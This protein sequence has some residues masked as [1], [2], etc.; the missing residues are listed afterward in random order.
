MI[1]LTIIIFLVILLALVLVHEWGHFIVAKLIGCTVE[2]FGFGF[3]PRLFGIK[4]RGTLYS[5]NTL[6]IGGFV[7]IEGEDMQLENNSSTNFAN[8]SAWKR[9]LVLAAGVTMNVILASV[10]LTFQGVV[11]VP[12]LVEDGNATQLTNFKTYIV[13]VSPGSPAEQAGIKALDRVVVVNSKD[14]PSITD[15]QKIVKEKAG[16]KISVEVDRQGQHQTLELMPRLNPPENE[17]ALGINLASTGLQRIPWWKAPWFGIKRTGDMLVAIV[18]QFW[19]LGQRLLAHQQ[20][21][22]ALTGPIGIA[23]YT[24]EATKMGVSYVLE[25]AA[26]IS[27]NLALVNILPLPA[28]DGGRILF[29]V[30]EKIF[31]RRMPVKVEQIIHTVGFAL[32]ILLMILIT[33]KDIRH[34]F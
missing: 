29:V 26:L 23:V 28:L 34:Y 6:P 27:L 15:I 16:Q 13:D 9:I 32:L 33:I 20:V 24:N 25:F 30:L 17:G 5:F 11:G 10:L 8:K 4:W 1:L 12:T 21:G 18:T 31:R 2:E 7:K 3:P 22:Q 14:N 19:M